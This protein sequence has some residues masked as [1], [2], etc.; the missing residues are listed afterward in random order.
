MEA[1]V[2]VAKGVSVEIVLL[3]LTGVACIWLALL[4]GMNDLS[5]MAATLMATRALQPRGAQLV[6]IGGVWLGILTGVAAVAQT[7]ALG[8]I[9]LKQGGFEHA[10]ALAVWFGGV[11]ATVIWGTLAR[12]L[13]IPTSA[14]HAFVGSLCG[15]TL[16]GTLRPELIHWGFR[17]FAHNPGQ[18]HGITKV[19]AG[20]V[21]SPI[22][23]G[24]L[25]YSIFKIISAS[26]RRASRKANTRIRGLECLAVL[27]QAFSYGT[28]DA[29][30]ITGVLVG[31]L[32]A[33]GFVQH[34]PSAPFVVPL[35]I[36]I[37]TA[38]S[39]SVGAVIGS[40]KIIRTMGRGLFHVLPAEAF[41]GQLAAAVSV[42]GASLTGAPVSST[43]VTSSALVGVGGAWRPR[44]VRWHKVRE[45]LMTWVFTFP[46]SA[47]IGGMIT[48]LIKLLPGISG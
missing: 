4:N 3:A 47:I 14:T 7:V 1:F 43:Q 19:L 11:V 44:H 27:L 37:L 9:D 32:T 2:L 30:K 42:Y 41:S 29:Q 38:V 25:G 8:L 45:I 35:W 33:S 34:A 39:I 21:L 13:G 40:A 28:N 17:E 18:L 26:L 10:P 23:G 20:L 48:F 16:A 31:A 15:A 6:A 24:A 36:Q 12:H 5:G 22:V 46:C